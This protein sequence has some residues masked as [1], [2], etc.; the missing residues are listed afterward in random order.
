MESRTKDQTYKE[1]WAALNNLSTE[2]EILMKILDLLEDTTKEAEKK[3]DANEALNGI[4]V[5]LDVFDNL[6]KASL[7]YL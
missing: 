7:I 5:N 4:N 2:K 6:E 1:K 3:L